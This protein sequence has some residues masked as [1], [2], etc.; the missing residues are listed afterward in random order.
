MVKDIDLSYF[1]GDFEIVS[2]IEETKN[3]EE[4]FLI[5]K[6]IMETTLKLMLVRATKNDLIQDVGTKYQRKLKNLKH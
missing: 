4:Y 5:L 1:E 2:K 3:H 6:M